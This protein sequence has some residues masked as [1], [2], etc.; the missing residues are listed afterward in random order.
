MEIGVATEKLPPVNCEFEVARSVR[1]ERPEVADE[2]W[3]VFKKAREKA[4]A[5]VGAKS[6]SK[7][8]TATALAFPRLS[9]CACVFLRHFLKRVLECWCPS[10]QNPPRTPHS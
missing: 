6:S 9:S 2:V 10:S 5:M 4:I 3:V 8:V 7:H 1:P